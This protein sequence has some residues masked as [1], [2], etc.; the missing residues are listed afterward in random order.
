[1]TAYKFILRCLNG[2]SVPKSESGIYFYEPGSCPLYMYIFAVGRAVSG[3]GIY[4]ER[5]REREREEGEEKA[6]L[7][8]FSASCGVHCLHYEMHM[9]VL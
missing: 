9:Y 7:A 8:L 3:G 5:G 4:R 1:M 2:Y 6:T